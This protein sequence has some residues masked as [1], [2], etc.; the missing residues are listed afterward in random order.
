M[1]SQGVKIFAR[2]VKASDL[3]ASQTELIG[4]KVGAMMRNKHFDPAGE[5][6]FVS[7]DGYV[8]DGHHRWAAQVARDLQ[9]GHLG[10][11]KLNVRVVNMNITD[12]LKAAKT[13]TSEFG[14]QPKAGA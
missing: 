4:T 2:S 14:I 3:K 12:V 10:D 8:I 1:A 5:A 6:I 9:N 13:F 11:L 7:K